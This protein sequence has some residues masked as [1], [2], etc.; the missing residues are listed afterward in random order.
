[1]EIAEIINYLDF[2]FQPEL[3]EEYDNAGFLL[4]DP[5]HEATGVLIAV[6]VTP[7]VIN[8]AKSKGLN[9]IV[10]HHPMIFSGVKHITTMNSLGKMIYDLIENGISVYAAH[11]NLDN[12]KHGVN[13]ILAEKLGMTDCQ[14]LRPMEGKYSNDIGA[15]MI[16]KLEQP[17]ATEDF[18]N[19][20]KKQL[21]VSQLRCSDLCKKEIRRVAICGGSGSFLIGDALK[22]RADIYLTADLKYH[23]F[24]QAE[25]RIILCDAGHYE[26]EQFT[27]EIIYSTISK[28]FRN[29]ACQISDEGNSFVRY[30]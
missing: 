28:K 9:L 1:M 2:A 13:G 21:N 16:G 18:L 3:Q 4:G 8:E 27:K 5:L 12:L 20:I 14:I 6:D 10:T 30:I 22:M 17:M 26:T 23:D 25:G 11:T 29:F 7:N 15:G 24:Q 19:R